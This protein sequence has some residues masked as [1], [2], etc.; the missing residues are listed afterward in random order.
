MRT[1]AT[2]PKCSG[3]KMMVVDLRQYPGE[4]LTLRRIPVVAFHVKQWLLS[5]PSALG[6]FEAW[7]CVGC[8]FTEL[9][10]EDLG[11]VDV[12]ELAAQYPDYVRI[13]DAAVSERGPFR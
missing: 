5:V 10:A 8:G 9:Y 12:E 13:V 3:K 4:S 6:R 11:D 2:C 7:I 1:T